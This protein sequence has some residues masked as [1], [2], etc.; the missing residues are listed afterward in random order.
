MDGLAIDEKLKLQ[1][2]IWFHIAAN[3]EMT[4]LNNSQASKCLRTNHDIST[5]GDVWNMVRREDLNRRH[6][7]RLNCACNVCK[8]DRNL[9][10]AKPFRCQ[11]VAN[12]IMDCIHPKWDPRRR[13]NQP[14]LALTPAERSEN[15]SA[16]QNKKP[17]TFDPNITVEKDPS[18]AFRT[19][20]TKPRHKRPADQMN[21][22]Q[23]DDQP[24][25]TVYDGDYEAG[26]GVWIA[27]DDTR[28]RPV[29]VPL[30]LASRKGGQL[31]AILHIIQ[32]T[33]I[34]TILHFR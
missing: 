19:F 9:G 7:R 23:M 6:Y 5:V 11:E 20:V 25:I 26:G 32:S 29:G 33:P 34:N 31:A 17:V 8:N 22:I 21:H 4:K 16:F 24:S 3:S 28:N 12:K 13:L 10:C 14:N 2:P 27:P 15:L 30:N 1:M 18:L